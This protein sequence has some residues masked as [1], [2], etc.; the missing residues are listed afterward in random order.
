MAN[1]T[2]TRYIKLEQRAGELLPA[3]SR[4]RCTSY[5]TETAMTQEHVFTVCDLAL[6]AQARAKNAVSQ[7]VR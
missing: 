1:H 3:L 4:R 6:E 5:R 2:G 7:P